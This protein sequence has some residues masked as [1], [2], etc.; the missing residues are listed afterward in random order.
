MREKADV[1]EPALWEVCPLCEV[2]EPVYLGKM[3]GTEH[4][5][6]RRCGSGW[7]RTEGSEE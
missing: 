6:C 2:G 7:Y 4:Y 5:R 1:G 3:G